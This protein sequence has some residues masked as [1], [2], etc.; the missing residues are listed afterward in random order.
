MA[1]DGDMGTRLVGGHR[2]PTIRRGRGGYMLEMGGGRGEVG[3]TRARQM[4]VTVAQRMV[5]PDRAICAAAG[6]RMQQTSD[7]RGVRQ[8]HMCCAI[9][10]PR[11]LCHWQSRGPLRIREGACDMLPRCGG[12]SERRWQRWV[13]V[14]VANGGHSPPSR[15]GALWH[16]LLGRQS[17]AVLWLA[18]SGSPLNI[19]HDGV[20]N[21]CHNRSTSTGMGTS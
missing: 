15:S 8:D 10:G 1:A 18:T 17:L 20:R 19:C 3:G 4:G 12:W 9:G 16:A 11:V 7:V 13:D 21:F 6:T 14:R 5:A 2:S